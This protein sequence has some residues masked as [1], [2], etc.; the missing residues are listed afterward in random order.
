M[1]QLVRYFSSMLVIVVG[2]REGEGGI[3]SPQPSV[4]AP[5]YYFKFTVFSYHSF[6]LQGAQEKVSPIRDD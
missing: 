6:L 4:T 5:E 1:E 3:P 2:H